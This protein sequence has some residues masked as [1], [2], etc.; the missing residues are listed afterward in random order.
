MTR[1]LHSTIAATVF[2]L[3]GTLGTADAATTV[4]FW[5]SFNKGQGEALAKIITQ[6]EAANPGIDVEAEF[7]GNYNDIVA[8][9]QAAIPARRAPDAVILEI[10]RYGLFAN[11]NILTDLTPYF[12]A[13]PLKSDLYDYAR[14]VGIINGKNYVVPFNS[15]TPVLYFNKDIFARAGL[16][17]QTP[18]K[19]FDN[20]LAAAK[21]ISEKL[22]SE[23]ISGIAAPG[24]FARWGLVMANDSELIDP[25]TNEIL[26]DKPNTVEAYQWMASLVN[27]HKV[28]SPDGVTDEDNGRDA[29]LAGKVGIMMNSTGNYVGSKKA[30][31]DNLVV[32]PMPCNKVCSVPIGGAGIGI[33]ASSPKEV[34]DAAY[35]FISYAASPE[36]NAAWFA[37]TGYLPIN[38]KSAALPVAVKAL[39]TQPGIDVAINSLPYAHGR[40]RSTVVTWMRSTEYKMWEAMALGQR[41]VDETMKDFAEQTRA[42]NQRTS[43]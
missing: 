41:K 25:T 30:I 5:H 29:F 15:S 37:A 26:L 18:L 7:I 4:K 14:E 2:A 6:F 21:T 19:T 3:F 43:N 8:K 13:D 17:A 35:K 11:N 33:M 38:K 28:A 22:G 23:G 34:Q 39:E 10:T 1:K 20:I 36:A 24:Q 16:S 27:H 9:L 42:E 32:R 12:D 31:G 40:A